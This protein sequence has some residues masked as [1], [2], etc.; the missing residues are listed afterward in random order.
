MLFKTPKLI[1]VVISVPLT[2]MLAGCNATN[3]YSKQN[4]GAVSGAVVGG[5]IGSGFGKGSGNIAATAI[6]ALAG[7]V[8]GGN[9]GADLDEKDRREALTAEYDALEYSPAGDSVKWRNDAS[10]HYGT[11]TPSQTYGVGKMNCRQYTHTIYIDG[12]EN[13]ARGTACK[14]QD[15]TWHPI[16]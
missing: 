8:I 6:G 10:G 11:V 3:F 2:I 12:K 1:S 9:I 13:T 5:A 15:G 16:T 14:E 7:G 4:I